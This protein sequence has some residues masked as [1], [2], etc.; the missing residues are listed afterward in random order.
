MEIPFNKPYLSKNADSYMLNAL[1]SLNHCGN[2]KWNKKCIDLLKE[3]YKFK[4]VFLL[5]SCTAA[6]EMGVMLAGIKPGDEVILPSYTFSSTAT[7]ILLSGGKPIFC[8][9]NPQTM[10]IDINHLEKLI[11]KKTKC[12]MPIDYAGITC[13]I[14]QINKIARKFNIPVLVDSAQSMNSKT[15]ENKWAGTCSE[16]AA[17]SFHE[18]KNFSCGEGGALIINKEEWIERAHFLQEKGTDRKLLIDGVKNKYGWVDI[19]SSYLLSNILGALLYSQLENI[20]LIQKLRSK[21]T[22]EYNKIIKPFESN[23]FIQS[24]KIPKGC[25]TNHHAYFLIFD[26]ALNKSRFISELKNNYNVSAYIHYQPLHSSKK[27]REL[28][29]SPEDLPITEDL[30]SK[31]VRLPLYAELG[32]NKEQLQY[33]S[34]SIKS[35]LINIYS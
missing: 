24:P 35:V 4:E 1:T 27:G 19:G 28:G 2:Q 3:K 7:A 14:E 9:I 5:P 32:E 20:D 21:V 29:Y 17:F 15:A 11:T 10:N 22:E 12:I 34:T 23:G 8:E 16:L 33:T 6:L 26:K 18:T 30:A 31:L 25:S 13:D